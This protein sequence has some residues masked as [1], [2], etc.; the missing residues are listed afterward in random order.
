MQ[1]E[2]PEV[3]KREQVA[4]MLGV[5]DETISN[6]IRQRGFPHKRIGRTLRFV[7]VDVLA[8]MRNNGVDD[9]SRAA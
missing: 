5:C 2:M 9:G 7:R 3:M 1:K 6:W 8:W 4:E